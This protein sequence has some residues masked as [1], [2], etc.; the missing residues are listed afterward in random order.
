MEHRR[1][2]YSC[3]ICRRPSALHVVLM[4]EATNGTKGCPSGS[5]EFSQRCAVG[6][7]APVSARTS[8]V[9]LAAL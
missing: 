5:T 9:E 1:D 7:E 8:L 3:C 4:A 6:C 2:V